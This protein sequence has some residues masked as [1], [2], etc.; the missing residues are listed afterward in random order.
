ML[1]K[2]RY[3]NLRLKIIILILIMVIMFNLIVI[4]I[5]KKNINKKTCEVATNYIKNVSL[6]IENNIDLLF[7]GANFRLTRNLLGNMIHKIGFVSVNIF[8]L[9]GELVPICL[10]CR[11]NEKLQ[12]NVLYSKDIID[13]LHQEFTNKFVIEKLQI[14]DRKIITLFKPYRNRHTCNNCHANDVLGVLNVNVDISKIIQF[15]KERINFVQS[16]LF[17]LSIILAV[18]IYFLLNYLIISPVRKIELAMQRISKGDLNARVEINKKDELGRLARYFNRMVK[19]LNKANDEVSRMHQNLLYSD[20][21]MTIGQ[22]TEAIS[23]EIKNPLNSIM[24]SVDLLKIKCEDYQVKEEIY[25]HLENIIIDSEKIKKIIDE[26]LSFS[27]RQTYQL[28][29]IDLEEFTGIL[30]LYAKRIIFKNSNVNFI[31]KKLYE[32]C[33]C[34]IR[35]NRIKLEQIFVH[36]I[37]N[38]V[39]A[40]ID[41]NDGLVEIEIDRKD[42]LAIFKIKDNGKGIPREALPH[43]FKEF[44]TTKKDGTGLG[45]S[46]VKELLEEIGVEYFIETKEGAG[47]TFVIK[48]PLII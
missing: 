32:P 39:E 8:N 17:M 4:N 40:C 10:T 35:F 6:L 37:K 9:N 33:E 26:T 44:Y 43:I 45:L 19:S 12:N 29:E 30:E 18:A 41:R 31:V 14:N 48:L 25:S 5:L 2:I 38:S 46:I 42:N 7:K 22:L 13:K 3:L 28:D 23:H 11:L 16:I 36:I 20:R 15:F 27:R 24:L 21:L 1:K 34:Y 47:T